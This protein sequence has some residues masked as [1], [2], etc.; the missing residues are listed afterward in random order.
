MKACIKLTFLWV[1]AT[2]SSSLGAD[3]IVSLFLKA[4]PHFSVDN[5]PQAITQQKAAKKSRKL[6]LPAK[7]A[8]YS[9]DAAVNNQA[10]AGIFATYAGQLIASNSDGQI[11]FARRQ[12]S[13][14]IKVLIT[15]Q[16][17]P[18]FQVEQTIS[19]WELEGDIPA[20]LYS[21]D[22]DRDQET[23]IE[24][25]DV[26]RMPLPQNRKI[27][28]DT[29][30]IFAPA[31]KIFIPEGIT[32]IKHQSADLILP[33]I[34]AKKSIDTLASSLYLINLKRLFS[35][36]NKAYQIKDNNVRMVVY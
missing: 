4:Y 33:E 32:P 6:Q 24:F 15:E 20:A 34:F 1:A 2:L 18:I 35:Q 16:I 23:E 25:W 3:H 31:D 9:L 27:G 29:I 26:K 10:Y 19:H 5:A 13:P 17:M 7:L 8:Q 11:I 36:V 21:F 14:N 28:L 30:V 22:Q 12:D